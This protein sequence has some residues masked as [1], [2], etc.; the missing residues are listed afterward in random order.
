[1]ILVLNL[2]AAVKPFLPKSNSRSEKPSGFSFFRKYSF[3]SF[4]ARIASP[5]EFLIIAASRAASLSEDIP[6]EPDFSSARSLI[7]SIFM[8]SISPP[9]ISI[10]AS[11]ASFLMRT[12]ALSGLKT[13]ISEFPIVAAR[14]ASSDA[15][16]GQTKNK[17]TKQ[18]SEM[19]RTVFFI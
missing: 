1:M 9:S 17:K 11:G 12:A 13:E 7:F 19:G 5:V 6:A 10:H 15:S 8:P 4:S 3:T 16:L 2:P 14:A 18:R